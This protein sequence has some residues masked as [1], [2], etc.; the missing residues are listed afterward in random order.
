M[1]KVGLQASLIQTLTKPRVCIHAGC[2]K[3]KKVSN[4]EF[5]VGE[6]GKSRSLLLKQ[7]EDITVVQG[8]KKSQLL[9]NCEKKGKSVWRD[10]EE[11]VLWSV[12]LLLTAVQSRGR[13]HKWMVGMIRQ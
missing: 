1:C 8:G 9:S 3:I 10:K 13:F 6:L 7:E 2:V 12:M 5:C 4:I 11:C